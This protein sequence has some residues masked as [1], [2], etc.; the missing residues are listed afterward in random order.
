MVPLNGPN[1]NDDHSHDTNYDTHR[2]QH[3]VEY[4]SSYTWDYLFLSDDH[5]GGG[6]GEAGNQKTN[7]SVLPL[8]M[9]EPFKLLTV[10]AIPK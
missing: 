3:I 9:N 6:G 8:T 1:E 2:I 10:N 5:I 7:I 4:S